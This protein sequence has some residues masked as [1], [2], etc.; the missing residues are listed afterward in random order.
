MVKLYFIDFILHHKSI[1]NPKR[2]TI[3]KK[4]K[5]LFAV[6]LACSVR[7]NEQKITPYLGSIEAYPGGGPGSPNHHHCS[8]SNAPHHPHIF[9]YGFFPYIYQYNSWFVSNAVRLYYCQTKGGNKYFASPEMK[10]KT[11]KRNTKYWSLFVLY[12]VFFFFLI[13]VSVLV[14]SDH[15]FYYL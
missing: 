14:T 2:K 6:G 1:I 9:F 8:Q 5:L 7:F 13:C 12:I 4:I 11:S 10:N 3:E 15:S